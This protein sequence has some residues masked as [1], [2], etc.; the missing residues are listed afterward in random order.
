MS[1]SLNKIWLHVI[2]STK[3]REPLIKGNSE[4]LIYTHLQEQLVEYGCYVNIINGMP[5]HVHL[6]FLQSPKTS[7]S[8][9]IKQIKGNTAHWINE[10][11]IIPERFSWQ[12]GY[13][14]YSVSESQ[15]DKVHQYIRNQ[16]SHHEK[17]TF[18]QEYEEFIAAHGL[19]ENING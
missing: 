6:L 12:T 17:K 1:H 16:K 13:A 18:K 19:T 5:D 2:F 11:N 14:A 7:V 10:Q 3:D 9:I 15:L 8:D 4:N